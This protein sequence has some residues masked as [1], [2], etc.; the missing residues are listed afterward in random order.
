MY[1]GHKYEHDNCS[2][3]SPS[4]HFSIDLLLK[5]FFL[6][7]WTSGVFFSSTYFHKLDCN[8]KRQMKL[9]NNRSVFVL[10]SCW[11]IIIIMY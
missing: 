7:Y 5:N 11:Y 10:L 6:S 3:N 8:Q 4:F 1:I 9:N 2:I